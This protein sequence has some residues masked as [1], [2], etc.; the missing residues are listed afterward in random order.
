MNK[1]VVG[2][3]SAS[4]GRISPVVPMSARE[5]ISTIL[6]GL[7]IGLIVAGLSYVM[8]RYVFGVVLC[9]PQSPT[10]CQQAPNYAFIVA[11]VVGAIASLITLARMRVYRPMLIVLAATIAL[12]SVGSLVSGAAWYV[13]VAV[14]VALFG[15]TY[16]L[17]AWVSRLRSF[18]LAI[19][20][21]I[22]LIAAM[23][24]MMVS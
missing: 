24:Y 15:F 3:Q 4:A 19:I 14:I 17:F 8:N 12:W 9:R 2:D 23:R 18:I 5:L 11:M 6:V 7:V 10:E 21:A 22:V 13:A 1:D 20:L 16:G